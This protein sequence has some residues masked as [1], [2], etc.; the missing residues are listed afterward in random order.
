MASEHLGLSPEAEQVLAQVPP[1]PERQGLT[2][3]ENRQAML[4]PARDL[5]A[6]PP[7]WSVRDAEVTGRAGPIPVRVYLPAP[8]PDS[9]LVFVHGGGWALGDLETHD[10]LC[11]SL[12]DL[13]G[14]AVV[15]VD[16]R[17]PPEHRFPAAVHDVVDTVR[18][19]LDDEAGL[20]LDGLPVA[21]GGDSA[22][23][24]L[25]A[26]AAQQLR[27][28]ERLVHQLLLVPVVDTHPEQWPSY[29][30]FATGLPLTRGDMDWYFEQYLP[31]DVDLDDPELAPLRCADLTGLPPATVITAGSDVLRNEG[32]A[33]ALRLRQ[34]GVPVEVRRYEGMFH[35][36]LL[37]GERL[38]G[39]R[40]AQSYAAGRLQAAFGQR[41]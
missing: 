33:Y 29:A 35:T 31:A 25:S 23:G 5:G 3:E 17:Q 15:A 12:A 8:E 10:A 30:E 28:H 6:G 19:L 38:S 11:R 16:Y 26:V 40:E 9:V 34:A 39:A 21:V 32:E 24:N 4:A 18:L 2:V 36:F 14:C 13:A 20:G 22:G 1:R 27:G 7:L 41:R 37:F